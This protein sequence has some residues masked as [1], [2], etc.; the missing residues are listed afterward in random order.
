MSNALQAIPTEYGLSVLRS[1]QKEH[2]ITYELIG[3]LTPDA[4]ELSTFHSA[5]IE[6]SYYDENKVLTFVLILPVET[7][8]NEYLHKITILDADSKVVIECATPKVALAKGIGGK[9]TLKAAITGEAGEIIFKN[10]EYITEP[11]MREL[12][13]PKFDDKLKEHEAKENPHPQYAK[14]TDLD[15]ID[16]SS[17][18]N[19]VD[20]PGAI[21]AG[22]ESNRLDSRTG[23]LSGDIS[24]S[25]L[26]T[27]LT[28]TAELYDG[29]SESNPIDIGIN[30]CDFTRPN[31]G[32]GYW[33]DRDGAT[34]DGNELIT[35]CTFDTDL[36]GWTNTAGTNNQSNERAQLAGL[37]GN[38]TV[39]FSQSITTEVGKTYIAK[40][41]V[42]NITREAGLAIVVAGNLGSYV[43]QISSALTDYRNSDGVS[44][45]TFVA[46][47]TT[48]HIGLRCG[49][50]S[51]NSATFD[52]VSVQK[53][54]GNIAEKNTVKKDDG[55]VVEKGACD[56]LEYDKTSDESPRGLSL[57]SL[58]SRDLAYGHQIYDG[59]RGALQT[60]ATQ[61][62]H[63]ESTEQG[64][65]S[66]TNTGFSLG[67]SLTVNSDNDT[68]IAYQSLYTKVCWGKTK[69]GKFWVMTYNPATLTGLLY[70]CSSYADDEVPNPFDTQIDYFEGKCL[71]NAQNWLVSSPHFSDMHLN[72]EGAQ[73]AGQHKIESDKET[74][75]LR[76]TSLFPADQEVIVRF[77]AK[78]TQW[79]IVKYAATGKA[80][81][82]IPVKDI[83][84]IARMPLK[85]TTKRIDSS[86][87]Y[88]LHDAYRGWDKY[89]QLN[90]N[91]I[92]GTDN[93][94]DFERGKI[95]TKGAGNNI[96]G[97]EYIALIEFDSQL[98]TTIEDMEVL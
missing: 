88:N 42:S 10:A 37:S 85:V 74:I 9:V 17:K 76:K 34:P 90:N 67:A 56:W 38:S 53:L 46:T 44:T 98:D 15:N 57:I 78:S 66:F 69:L 70:F 27:T 52:N 54:V 19:V 5:K 96:S 58:K 51:A 86:S 7:D 55:T 11:E 1:A 13:L 64:G 23:L 77:R 59:L 50:D 65:L 71:T 8:F 43:S 35:N 41:D 92:E 3:A 95:T 89:I 72:T 4:T 62:A 45:I 12:W 82:V 28:D 49:N 30:S 83:D 36:S 39:Y 63:V 94:A 2:A 68:L 93:W 24:L 6:S 22:I 79:T 31:N 25:N 47:A 14:K 26:I 29:T 48:T 18:V 87:A 73:N 75:Y 32:S 84:G 40:V 33:L 80:G 97:G 60:I 21:R 16:M 91:K 81:N 20:L 61:N